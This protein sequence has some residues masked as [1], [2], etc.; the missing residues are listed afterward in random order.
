M[1]TTQISNSRYNIVT[2][3]ELLAWVYRDQRAHAMSHHCLAVA[4]ADQA[5]SETYAVSRDGLA[6]MAKDYK[7][8][9]SIPTTA[10]QQRL[11]LH[12]D[13]ETV[14]EQLALLSRHDPYGALLIFRHALRAAI[15]DYCDDTPIP[16]AVHSL[17]KNGKEKVVR[18]QLRG[19]DSHIE[20]RRIFN[21]ETNTY[22]TAWVE[23]GYPYCPLSYWPSIECV[24]E[25]RRDYR[26]WINAL[27]QLDTMLPLLKKWTV[28]GLG[29][30]P[31]PWAWDNDNHPRQDV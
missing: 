30:D 6:K 24:V 3:V 5:E 7:L 12:P 25:S 14:H 26:L 1:T 27:T 19:G 16:Q 9:A 8:G 21:K 2:L 13:A 4:E 15:P 31:T 11:V 18:A 22:R 29:A 17:D 20:Q 23:V 28:Q 10:A